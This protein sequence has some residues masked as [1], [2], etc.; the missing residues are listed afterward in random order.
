MTKLYFMQDT[1]G[2]IFQT[3]NPEYHKQA[4]KLPQA[5]GKELYRAQC[6][7]KVKTMLE[8]VSTVYGIV[9]HV[10][11]SGM[12][13]DIDLYIIADNRPV[14]LTGYASTILDYPMAKSRG[15]KVG[16]CGMD[17]VFHCVSSLAYAIGR[18]YKT[19]KSE[20]I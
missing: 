18:D 19:L 15:M 16:G 17:M 14:Y 2:T 11:A 10:S 1:D 4:E 7:D 9:R 12:S 6:I 20:I 8:N 13:R 3:A 5:K